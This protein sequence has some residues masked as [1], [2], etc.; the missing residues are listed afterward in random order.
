MNDIEVL[1]SIKAEVKRDPLANQYTISGSNLR[2]LLRISD[3]AHA[4]Y[5]VLQS[6]KHKNK[7]LR[8]RLSRMNDLKIENQMLKI[9]LQALERMS[10]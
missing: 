2:K 6:F 8:S 1:C 3:Q 4:Q 9:Q 5:I 7:V 10:L